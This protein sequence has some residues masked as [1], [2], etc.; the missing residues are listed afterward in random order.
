MPTGNANFVTTG[1][2][3][4]VKGD[5]TKLSSKLQT[6]VTQ[7]ELAEALCSNGFHAVVDERISQAVKALG[8]DRVAE[9]IHNLNARQAKIES[10]VVSAAGKLGKKAS[11][12]FVG[13]GINWTADKLAP[14]SKAWNTVIQTI[15][16][17][18]FLGCCLEGVGYVMGMPQIRPSTYLGKVF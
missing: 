6:Y 14:N 17:G 7:E 10:D 3:G 15:G 8:A 18:T 12:T 16:W 13:R 2:L 1:Q 11:S 9:E 5:V 4:Q